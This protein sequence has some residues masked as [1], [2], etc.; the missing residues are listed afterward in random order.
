MGKKKLRGGGGAG[1]PNCMGQG[2]IMA[3]LNEAA[4]MMDPI[5]LS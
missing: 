5:D 4:K 2:A 1:K 3:N